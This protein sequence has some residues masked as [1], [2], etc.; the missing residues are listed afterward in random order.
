MA[1]TLNLGVTSDQDKKRTS[2]LKY[3]NN[4]FEN[5]TDYVYF[6][7]YQ[8][9]GPFSGIGGNGTSTDASGK[10]TPSDQTGN[11]AYLTYNSTEYKTDDSLP[12]IMLYM[13]ED[14]STGYQTDWG[15]KGFT[16]TAADILRGGG[17]L[18]NGEVKRTASAITNM[19]TR[20]A[21]ALPTMGAESIA[22][23]INAL[24][25]GLGGAGVNTNDVLQGA[26]GVVLNPNTELMFNGFTLRNFTLRFKLAPRSATEAKNIRA[27]INSFKAASRP[28]I[29]SNAS[30][31]LDINNIA[32]IFKDTTAEQAS[33]EQ[34]SDKDNNS[35][36]VGVPDLCQVQFRKGTNP[37]P[38]LPMW[39]MCAITDVSVNYTPDGTYA[40]YGGTDSEAY[41]SPVATELSLTFQETKLIYRQDI[42]IEGTSY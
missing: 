26:M 29:G 15:G 27:I 35:N 17:S 16:N 13:P 24:P 8:Y 12:P 10:E 33:A 20:A 23:G 14:I 34:S 9:N 41:G 1:E 6:R 19:I 42:V 25:G 11:A 28:K 40:T 5:N 2:T 21:G 39:K 3:P 38:Y 22:N 36:Y 4:L 32:N 31:A 7:F 18:V 37:H 30:G